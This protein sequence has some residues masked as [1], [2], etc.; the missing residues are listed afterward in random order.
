MNSIKKTFLILSVLMIITGCTKDD[1]D[2]GGVPLIPDNNRVWY[3][4]VSRDTLK[5]TDILTTL[6]GSPM[7]SVGPPLVRQSFLYHSI[8]KSDTVTLSGVVCWP[9]GYDSCNEIWLENHYFTIRW[10]ECPSQEPQAGMLCGSIRHA[11]YIGADYQG[12]GLSREMYQPYSNTI[13]LANQSIDCFKAAY[14]VL[15]DYGPKLADDYYTYSMGSSLGGAVT[16]GIARQI[17]LDPGLKELVRLKKSFCCGGPY[18]MKALFDVFLETPDEELM[19]PV[20][21]ICSVKGIMDDSPAFRKYRYS[22]CF[23]PELLNIG[24]MDSIETKLFDAPQLNHMIKDAGFKSIRDIL[25]DSIRNNNS[26]L[27]KDLIQELAGLDLTVGWSPSSPILLR[28]VRTDLNIPFRCLE[29]VQAN[30][31]DNGN[32][33]YE[34]IESGNHNDDCVAFY[35]K[36]IF[37]QY[38]LD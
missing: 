23:T 7:V 34:I 27:H 18:D 8:N 33:T 38:P 9:E 6:I 32:I 31:P 4:L 26:A 37:G 19:Y 10:N 16:F 1:Y 11:V 36:L 17:E 12:Q 5:S 3:E 20:G 2:E 24:I 13:L 25:S 22:D 28:H 14:S 30:M 35:K 21:F 29:S 15:Q